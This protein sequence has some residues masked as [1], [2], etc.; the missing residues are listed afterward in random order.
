M[1]NIGKYASES[2][3]QQN[4]VVGLIWIYDVKVMMSIKIFQ[5]T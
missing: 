1:W 2:I 4:P 3:T 5:D